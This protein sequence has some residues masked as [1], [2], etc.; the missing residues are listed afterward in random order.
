MYVCCHIGLY[1]LDLSLNHFKI[2]FME[3]M[4][5]MM[6]CQVPTE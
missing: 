5:D 3:V 1:G 4:H 6:Q 2:K